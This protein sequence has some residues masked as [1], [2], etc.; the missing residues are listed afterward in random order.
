M[1]ELP[2][3]LVDPDSDSEALPTILAG[4]SP[5]LASASSAE[6]NFG[7]NYKR[8][9]AIKKK[10]DPKLLFCKWFVISPA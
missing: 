7:T 2:R 8:L 4:G 6:A 9:Q 5:A 10:Y 3:S 1:I